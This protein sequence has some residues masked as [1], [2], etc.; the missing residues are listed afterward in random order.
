MTGMTFYGSRVNLVSRYY[1][2]NLSFF[3]LLAVTIAIASITISAVTRITTV[4]TASFAC[5]V[6]APIASIT[7]PFLTATALVAREDAQ[8]TGGFIVCICMSS[9]DAASGTAVASL[10]TEARGGTRIIPV[11]KVVSSSPLLLLILFLHHWLL[12]SEC[13]LGGRRF[14]FGYQRRF[15]L[16]LPILHPMHWLLR[17]NRLLGGRL[18]HFTYKTR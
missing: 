16:F 3:V 11:H 17:D 4:A 18:I 12:S 7:A 8:T 14:N 6:A 1:G 5:V 2:R 9:A 13:L 10:N 15:I